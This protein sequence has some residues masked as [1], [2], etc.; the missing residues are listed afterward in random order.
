M[1]YL[2]FHCIAWETHEFVLSCKQTG[3][4]TQSQAIDF[5]PKQIFLLLT[6]ASEDT[7][8]QGDHDDHENGWI[9]TSFQDFPLYANEKTR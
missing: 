4:L 5:H 1:H 3:N 6:L 7:D 9:K 2:H 8:D